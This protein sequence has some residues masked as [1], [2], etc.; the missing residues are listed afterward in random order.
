MGCV[1]M[2]DKTD[3][4]S[5]VRKNVRVQFSSSLPADVTELAYVTVLETVFW[6][7]ESSRPHQLLFKGYN[8]WIDHY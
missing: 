2:E 3:L 7:F 8:F 6:R 4:K 5:V 1:G